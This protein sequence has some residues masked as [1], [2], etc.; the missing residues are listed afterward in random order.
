MSTPTIQSLTSPKGHGFGTA[1]VFLAAISTILGTVLFL[2]FGYAVGHLG[3]AGALW[4]IFLGHLVTIPT[5][6]AVAE[7]ATN[8]RVEGGGE[9]YIISRSF[10]TTIG[11]TIG[12]SLYLSQAVSVAF[13][14]IAF[15]QS[16][17]D[18]WPW[19]TEQT[20][21]PP[22]ARIISLPA[23]LLLIYVILKKGANLGV[24]ILWVVS[25]ILFVALAMFFLGTGVVE[26]A[27]NLGSPIENA[28]PFMKVFAIVFPA[29]TGMTAGVGL[30]GDLKNPRRSI[31]LGTLAGTLTGMAVYVLLVWKLSNSAEPGILA[32]TERFVM[33][34]IALWPP[35]IPIG[36]AAAT[37]SSAIGSILVA[38]RTMQVLARDGVFPS[39]SIN[40]L[41]AKG[42]GPSDEPVRATL[43]S[44]VIAIVFIL[45]GDIDT[46]SQVISMFFMVTYGALCSVSFLEHF[47]GNPSYRPSFRSRWYVSLLGALMCFMMMFQMQPLYA[48]VS[49]VLMLGIY[50][51]LAYTRRGERDVSQIL[52][53]VMFQLTR[54]L[55]IALQQSRAG[56]QTGDWRPSFF[57]LTRHS[58]DRVA[59][60]D[61][62]RWICHRQGFGQFVQYV[63]GGLS[64]EKGVYA[65]L[66]TDRLIQKS[67]VSKAGI[68]VETVVAPS[69]KNAISQIIQRPGISG[70]P[71]N[72]ALFEFSKHTPE[73][74]P[75][76]VEGAQHLMPFGFNVCILRSTELRFGYRS[77]IHIWLTKDDFENAPLMIL[78]AYIILG[79]RDWAK[80]E[81]NIFACYPADQTQSQLELLNT[82]VTEGRLP[83]S[84]KNLTAVPYD[85]ETGYSRTVHRK[86][87]GADLLIMGLTCA[88]IESD[89]ATELK[90]HPDLN[91][92]LFVYA[93]QQ[94]SIS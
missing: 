3:S 34:D 89:L 8:R 61:L 41:L 94:I 28:D 14:M 43:A 20:G 25:I 40:D 37:L 42:S 51:W 39:K 78:L 69:F 81:I 77:S 92:V 31:P 88:E 74:L 71:N 58:L 21:L 32:N 62:L 17:Q 33:Q 50:R 83:I 63:E 2:R 38:P 29:F 54:R 60:F 72:S 27:T 90:S 16:F 9:Y 22:D 91:E 24:S 59:Q 48:V 15:A 57:A 11:G 18:V 86:S 10:G 75:E 93:G 87:S 79:H 80:A 36:L 49:L 12:I 67:E 85:D 53:G 64:I 65:R 82:F 5:A 7:I 4:V 76:V 84:P 44:G 55:Q 47:S 66:F 68:F 70:L 13:Y 1:P 35:I 6:M 23:T 30:S 73:E 26:D 19:I 45:A 46:V 52:R 56:T